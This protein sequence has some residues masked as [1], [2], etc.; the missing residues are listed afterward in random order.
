MIFPFGERSNL[1]ET[2]R[3]LRME[4]IDA[5][6]IDEEVDWYIEQNRQAYYEEFYEYMRANGEEFFVF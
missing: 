6:S 3:L 1:A 5:E 2:N 4:S